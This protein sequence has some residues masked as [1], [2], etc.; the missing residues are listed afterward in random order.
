MP[1]DLIFDD[2]T[3]IL[4][5]NAPEDMSGQIYIYT[6]SGEMEAFSDVLNT[7]ISL[8]PNGVNIVLIQ[9]ETWIGEA[10]LYY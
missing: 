3:G 1:I 9:G 5:C 4:I 8:N 2:E 6:L 10:K 7:S